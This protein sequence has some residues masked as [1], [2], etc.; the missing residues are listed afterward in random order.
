MFERSVYWMWELGASRASVAL[1]WV[2]LNMY[3]QKFIKGDVVKIADRSFLENF[4]KTWRYHH[5]LEGGQLAFAEQIATIR[6]VGFY[7]GGDV[8]YDL[9]GIPGIWHEQCLKSVI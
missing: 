7:H 6:D 1:Y 8:L 3:P 5:K 4:S 2:Y 9:E